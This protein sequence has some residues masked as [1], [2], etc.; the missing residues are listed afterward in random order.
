MMTPEKLRARTRR[1]VSAAADS[2]RALGLDVREP[3]VLHDAF[4]VV[5]HLAPA[6]VAV[7]VPLVLPPDLRNG[8][9]TVRQQ[10]ELDAAAWL[11]EQGFPVVPPSA[12]VPRSPVVRDGFSMTFWEMAN[13]AEDHVPYGAVDI[14]RVVDLHAALRAWPAGAGLPFLAPVAHTVPSLLMRLAPAPDLLSTAD[15][16][17]ARREWHI[18]NPVLG[19]RSAFEARFPAAAIQAVHGDGP[20]YN[21]IRTTSGIRFADFEDVSLAPIEW[22]LAL[23]TPEDVVRYDEEASRRGAPTV[24][25]EIL[26]VMNAARMLQ[27]VASVALV[28]ELPLLAAGLAPSLAAWRGMPLAGGLR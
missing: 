6:P 27:M 19:S 1:A 21:T 5:V 2:G 18:L 9:L 8:R 23:C 25:P 22:D 12:L 14:A 11:A 16:E 3:V 13:V 20:S 7:R 15:V 28:P 17:R 10:R 4:S 24:D 26:Q